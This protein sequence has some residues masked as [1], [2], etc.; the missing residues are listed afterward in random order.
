MRIRVIRRPS[1]L[2][3]LVEALQ[4]RGFINQGSTLMG[5]RIRE[6]L[7]VVLAEEGRKP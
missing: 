4:R 5:P 1:S 7:R 3:I 6:R 2:P